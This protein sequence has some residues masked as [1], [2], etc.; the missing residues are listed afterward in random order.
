M[1]KTKAIYKLSVNNYMTIDLVCNYCNQIYKVIPSRSSTS[2]YCSRKC[3]FESFKTRYLSVNNPAYGKKRPDLSER[4]KTETQILA[5]I[6]H[7]TGK[8][9]SEETKRKIGIAS[10][11][12]NLKLNWW[13]GESNPFYVK[14]SNKF[15]KN[16]WLPKKLRLEILER[17]N[18][19]CKEC[20]INYYDKQNLLHVHHIIP[21]RDGGTNDESNLKTLCYLCHK[22]IDYLIIKSQR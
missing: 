17:D 2:K 12:V 18:Y 6:K 20:F 1:S 21:R 19:T 14:N 22:K 16:I 5:V 3:K 11:E 9:K 13:K 8:K 15:L 10:R 4:N 7:N